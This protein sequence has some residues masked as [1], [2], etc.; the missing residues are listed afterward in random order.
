VVNLL[1]QRIITALLGIPI[2]ILVIYYGGYILL[3]AT[4]IITLLS[5]DELF[6]ALR[7]LQIEFNRGIGF[8]GGAAFVITSHYY[9]NVYI[10]ETL[11]SVTALNLFY[12]IYA[13]PRVTLSGVGIMLLSSI[14][15]GYFLSF[16]ILT[17][18]LPYGLFFL[19]LAFILAWSTDVGGYFTGLLFGKHKLHKTLSPNK[20]VEGA[21]GG[22]LLPAAV[23]L[24][25]S[26]LIPFN[27]DP[28][29][30]IMLGLLSGVLG[31]AGD[32]IASAIKRQA[33]IKDFGNILPGHGGF[34]DRFDSFLVIIPL[35]YYYFE[36]FII[37]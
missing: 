31:Q 18:N 13:F 6:R 28:L 14:Y 34:L 36:L 2:I 3:L 12:Y 26:L 33:N 32:L 29:K 11:F 25:F 35:V 10:P 15:I 7:G 8:L 17:R 21:F 9:G 4:L 19:L 23:A 24:V 1:R 20:T 5:L 30:V 27:I 16:V 22:I 37:D